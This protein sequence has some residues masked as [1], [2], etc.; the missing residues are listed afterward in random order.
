MLRVLH[1]TIGGA[2]QAALSSEGSIGEDSGSK[3][4]PVVGRTHF[5]GAIKL[6]VL[7]SPRPIGECLQLKKGLSTLLK[8]ILLVKSGEPASVPLLSLFFLATG[9]VA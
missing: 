5:F 9:A 3:L 1:R 4:I 2:G 6:M 7:A 8:G